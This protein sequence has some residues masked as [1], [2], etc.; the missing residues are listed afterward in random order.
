LPEAVPRLVVGN[1]CDLAPGDAGADQ[2]GAPAE[3]HNPLRISALAGEGRDVL[4]ERLLGCCGAAGLQGL[5]QALNDRQADLAQRAAVALAQSG[6][7][8]AAGLP[9]DFWTIDLRQ[10]VR[11]LGEITGAEINEAVLE[12]VFSRFCIGK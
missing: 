10:A 12:R 4:V 8:A 6:E 11:L 2:H 3:P 9:W 5:Q 1:K 7:A